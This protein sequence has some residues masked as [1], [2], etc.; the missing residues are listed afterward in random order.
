MPYRHWF[1]VLTVDG[2]ESRHGPYA[3]RRTAE[4]KSEQHHKNAPSA[5]VKLVYDHKAPRGHRGR[6][7]AR[8]SASDAGGPRDLCHARRRSITASI[9]QRSHFR[10]SPP[11][12]RQSQRPVSEQATVS[13][14]AEQRPGAGYGDGHGGSSGIGGVGVHRLSVVRGPRPLSS[15]GASAVCAPVDGRGP[16]ECG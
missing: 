9:A 6:T 5:A 16:R 11:G 12:S 4:R 7:N 2:V 14:P 10:Q 8:R 15:R 13:R 1:V 3:S